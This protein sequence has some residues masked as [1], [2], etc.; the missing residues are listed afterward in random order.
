MRA[1]PSFFTRAVGMWQR[2]A[3]STVAQLL[4]PLWVLW[5]R[6]HWG[7]FGALFNHYRRHVAG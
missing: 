2:T 5:G 4:Q 1:V 3:L 6:G 7:P